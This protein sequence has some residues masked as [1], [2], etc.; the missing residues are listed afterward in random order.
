MK[1]KNNQKYNSILTVICHIIK[2]V[3][4]ILIQNDIIA[5]NFTKLFFEHVE[6]HFDFSR[7]IIIDKK[8]LHYFRFLIKNL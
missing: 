6:C 7:S 8:F 3:L 5:T 4:F 2:Y 1:T